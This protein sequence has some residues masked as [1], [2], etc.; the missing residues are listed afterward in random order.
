LTRNA[1]ETGHIIAQISDGYY[2]AGFD[3]IE[4][5]ARHPDWKLVIGYAVKYFRQSTGCEGKANA[6]LVPARAVP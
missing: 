1:T 5:G 2:L 3:C 6:M 4:K